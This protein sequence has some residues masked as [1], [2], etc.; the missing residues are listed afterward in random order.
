MAWSR[1]SRHDRG[2]GTEWVKLR[3]RILAR[4]RHL[5]QPCLR[6]GRPTTATEVDHIKPKVKGGT[7]A[8]ANLEAI[9]TP[10][11]TTKTM[12]ESGRNAKRR[13]EIGADG[14]PIDAGAPAISARN[15]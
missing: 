13:A 2:Y 7:D 9:C 11:H 6:D 14:W 4:D 3:K 5:C 8:E 1:T 15:G 10:C 12:R